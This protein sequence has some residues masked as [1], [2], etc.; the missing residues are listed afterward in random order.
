MRGIPCV[1]Y[2]RNGKASARGSGYCGPDTSKFSYHTPY[3][4]TGACFHAVE[5]RVPR[6]CV[7]GR[8]LVSSE[9]LRCDD[10][11]GCGALARGPSRAGSG[12]P[13]RPVPRDT[14]TQDQP[15]AAGAPEPGARVRVQPEPGEPELLTEGAAEL[16]VQ[17]RR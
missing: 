11:A 12:S 15:G 17:E 13:A 9:F 3:T 7:T 14:P 2:D 16:R 4:P 10:P 6:S 5:S 1:S 8:V